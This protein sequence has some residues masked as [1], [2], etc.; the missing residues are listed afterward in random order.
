M[1]HVRY[2]LGFR[3]AETADSAILILAV[4]CFSGVT[5][6][7]SC[8][9][10]WGS[11]PP[12]VTQPPINGLGVCRTEQN[13]VRSCAPMSIPER[14]SYATKYWVYVLDAASQA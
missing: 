2:R 11:Q 14:C 10:F 5:L 13:K 7:L 1:Q 6:P 4:E 8:R 9:D 12:R 3:R